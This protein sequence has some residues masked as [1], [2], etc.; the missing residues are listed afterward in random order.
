MDLDKYYQ[1]LEEYLPLLGR[2]LLGGFFV[3]Q[4][5][6]K[7]TGGF[8]GF[9]S[10]V[11]SLGIPVATVVAGIVVLIEILGGLAILTGYKTRFVGTLMATYIVVVNLIAHPFWAEADQLSAFMKNLGLVGGL[12]LQSATGSDEYTLDSYLE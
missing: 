1:E 2:I 4:G 7:L 5:A 9:A 10:Y 6:T 8:S 12:L 3:F 11:E